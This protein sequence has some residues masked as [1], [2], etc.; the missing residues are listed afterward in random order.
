MYYSFLK[1]SDDV[2][3]C[4]L[5]SNTNQSVI[6]LYDLQGKIL[7][8]TKNISDK[9]ISIDASKLSSGFYLLQFSGVGFNQTEKVVVR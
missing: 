3:A 7:F 2:V 1:G 9:N 8:E 6:R 4:I 5:N